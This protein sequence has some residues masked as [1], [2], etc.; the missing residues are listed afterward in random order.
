MFC[1]TGVY[2]VFG[3]VG[4]YLSR[5]RSLREMVVIPIKSGVPDLQMD[6]HAEVNLDQARGYV[7]TSQLQSFEYCM[8]I[9]VSP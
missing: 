3:P 6:E 8:C 2:S 4:A 9:L 1:V 7:Q 5:Q